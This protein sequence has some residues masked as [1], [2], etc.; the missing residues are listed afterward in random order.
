MKKVFWGMLLTSTALVT[1]VIGLWGGLLL[2]GLGGGGFLYLLVG[3][4]TALGYYLVWQG[5]ASLPQSQSWEWAGKI[6]KVLCAY[7]V[8]TALLGVLPLQLPSTMTLI[9]N[10][11]SSLG[12]FF[13]LYMIVLG[14]RELQFSARADL[15]AEKL[16][17]AFVA[18]V[19]AGLLTNLLG[20]VLGFVL[21][22]VELVAYIAILVLL[23]KAARKY[24]N[25]EGFRY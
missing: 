25:D 16:W 12:S 11:V 9:L 23:A 24:E 19:V 1:I 7:T 6:A 10:Y 18:Y 3:L 5:A 22:I 14:V 13:A 15:G 20:G 8:A 2:A 17:K 21:S 4:V